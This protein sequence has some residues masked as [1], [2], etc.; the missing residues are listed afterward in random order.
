MQT[1]LDLG[2]VCVGS[3]DASFHLAEGEAVVHTGS[4][5]DTTHLRRGWSAGGI[6]LRLKVGRRLIYGGSHQIM[7]FVHPPSPEE[8][9]V[10][11][12]WVSRRS[13]DCSRGGPYCRDRD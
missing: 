2:Q 13:G 9:C 11:A 1:P 5:Q 6:R 4:S 10:A 12:A 8:S 7:A 3:S